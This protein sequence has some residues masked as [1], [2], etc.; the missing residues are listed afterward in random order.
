MKNQIKYS[1]FSLIVML[2]F[3]SSVMGQVVYPIPPNTSYIVTGN[4]API[5]NT[6][7][8]TF[9]PGVWI[10]SGAT[11]SAKIVDQTTATDPYASITFSNEN[12]VFTRS[13]QV[14][15][16]SFNAGTSKEGD[17][18]ESIAYFDGLGRA[19]QSVNIKGSPTKK[20]IVTHVGYDAY[21]RQAK[22]YLPFQS[23]GT[24]G[25]YRTGAEGLTTTYYQAN[26]GADLNT[27][28]LN[29]F[30]EKEL[31]ASPLSRVLK[32]GAPGYAWRVGGGHE[33]KLDYQTNGAS[34]I[35][36]YTV[37]FTGGNTE[38]PTLTGGTAYYGAGE[39]YKTITK[40]ENW[41]S[42]TNNTTEEFT[43]KQGRVVLK[44]TYNGTAYDTYYVYDV[45]GNL[46][47]VLPPKSEP[48]SAKPD[49]TELN[50]LCYQYKYDSRNRLI[51]KKIPGK[52][53]VTDWEEIVYNKLDQPILT[54]D[55]NLKAQGKWLFTKYD[56][57]GRVAYTG[58]V[59]G[60]TRSTHQTAANGV[61]TSWVVQATGTT[62]IGGTPVYYNNGGYP[63]GSIAEL[64]SI[65]YY[66]TYIDTDGLTVPSTVLTQSTATNRKGLATVSKVRV[67][68]TN[69]WITSVTGYDGKGRGIYV[70]S[71]NNYLNTT[72]I[73]ETELDFGGKAKQS[74]T[75]HKRTGK[76]DIVTVD[77][78]TYDHQGRLLRQKQKINS[79]SEVTLV[80]NTYD[81]LGQL[82]QKKI[83][84][85]LQTVDYTYNIRGWLKQINNPASLGTDLFA[86]KIN[87][88]TVAHGGNA[89][90]NG[91]ISETEWRTANTDNSLK[92]YK[93]NYDP[94]NR[95]TGATDNTTNYN[96]SNIGYDKNGNITGLQRKGVGGLIDNLS[97]N[98]H[99]SEVSNKLKRVTDA[100]NNI[101]G[102]KDGAN[103]TEEYTYDA[104]GNMV[105]DK[106][107]GITAITYNHLN[108]PTLVSIGG[109]TISYLY[110]ATGVKQRK[111]VSTGTTTDYAGNYIY[112]DSQL[113]FF[114]HAEG[115][116]TP[117]NA[118]DYSEGF[119]YVYQYKDHLGNIRLSYSD[120]DWNGSINAT[121][122]IIEENN[123]YPFGLRH[124]G[125]NNVVTSTNPA[126]NYTFNGKEEQKELGLNW[127]DFGARNYDASLGRWMNL[128]PLAENYSA[129]SPYVYALNNPMF[130]IDPDGRDVKNA[131]EERKKEAEKK[132]KA[133]EGIVA[134]AESKYG[135]DKGSFK[136]KAQ[137][138]RYKQAKRDVNKSTREVAK[139]TRRSAT[140]QK[141]I[142]DFK[143]S[144]PKMFAAMDNIQNQ[145]GETVDVMVGVD[146][147]SNYNG[148]N[149]Y[150]FDTNSTGEV[151]Q[152]T[153]EFGMN[154]VNI[155][156]NEN[157]VMGKSLSGTTPTTLEVT[158]HEMGHANYE[159]QNAKSFQTYLNSL[160]SS[161]KG[162]EGHNSGNPSGTNATLWE[163][164]IDI[165]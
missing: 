108:L 81:D 153:Q 62:T 29:P 53:S 154:T 32:Q 20:D 84:G 6:Q 134:S 10:K 66:D 156:L 119:D 50:E 72:D 19:M 112:E 162:K 88:N 109:G 92:W 41:T 38:S 160:K 63:T 67:L 110:D 132:L 71:K 58:L 39:L 144:S 103:Q 42:G 106:N 30:S 25:T 99:D 83:G 49:A 121:T 27:N 89:L 87:Y 129:T 73:V 117:K 125:Y 7:S 137:Y 61:T 14:G 28:Y 97:Y 123:F 64:H 79:Q 74:K 115:Y 91:N 151:R 135:T 65:N 165:K 164:L 76:T 24:L 57:F 155:F 4:T 5:T 18:L 90:F 152:K 77:S 37:T 139:Y 46:T 107:K 56:A 116:I 23:T 150:S 26:Y 2:F 126:Q 128:D 51:E 82:Q 60:G 47:Y 163:G 122:E 34:Q 35:R 105:T 142:D 21:G 11:F 69:N 93:Y 80:D 136:D 98:Y 120:A 102:F 111:V 138:K 48:Q 68:T 161:A 133:N 15:M 118:N 75:T 59:S 33:I 95:I 96:V 127:L 101:A 36:L 9:K 148:K 124:K 94:L 52:G 78:F 113:Q 141:R 85:A 114:N 100:S 13:Y 86:F 12:Y 146:N 8:I 45:Y 130:F 16:T 158:K 54:R 143:A 1:F 22:D 149:E 140:T 44:R 157:S 145:Y 147:M 17:V 70:A 31:E 55:P 104:N 40:D 131:D 3:G 159:I 43:D